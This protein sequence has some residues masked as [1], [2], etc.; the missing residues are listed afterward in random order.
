MMS[1]RMMNSS[2]RRC[3]STH[4]TWVTGLC[5]SHIFWT[6][7]S[8]YEWHRLA[9][10][11]SVLLRAYFLWGHL[12]AE[13]YT[14]ERRT[15]QKLKE[16]V[17]EE[18]R[19]IDKGLLWAVMVISGHIYGNVMLAEE[20]SE[21]DVIFQELRAYINPLKTKRRLLYLKTQFVP[22]SKHFSSRL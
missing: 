12:K 21:K 11:V 15:L 17:R 20:N 7:H 4:S 2:A 14:N 19:A 8:T 5:A 9:G 1:T 16:H 3:H 10:Q 22:R 13:V 6:R 18:I